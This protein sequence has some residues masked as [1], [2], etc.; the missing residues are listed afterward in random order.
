MA[1]AKHSFPVTSLN[2]NVQNQKV[3]DIEKRDLASVNEAQGLATQRIEYTSVH[4][5]RVL[6][7]L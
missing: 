2:L 6:A 7:G 4:E 1:K 3:L 5:L